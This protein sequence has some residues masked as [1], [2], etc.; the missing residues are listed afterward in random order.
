MN[1]CPICGTP[2]EDKIRICPNCG[3]AI[4]SVPAANPEDTS[5][6]YGAPVQTS[7]SMPESVPEPMPKSMPDPS[8][9]PMPEPVPEPM[10]EPSPDF[11]P[12]L[13]PDDVPVQPIW[14][15]DSK[16]KPSDG[17]L[18][19]SFL[20]DPSFNA[21]VR[22]DSYS[23]K[24]PAAYDTQRDSSTGTDRDVDIFDEVADS[25]SL[26]FSNMSPKIKKFVIITIITTLLSIIPFIYMS[27]THQSTESIINN[28]IP[29]QTSWPAN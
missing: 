6:L 12:G 21:P 7:F 18:D 8:P 11:M 23:K 25:A 5:F 9:E 19:E 4:G 22:E 15:T 28:I 13:S 1:L 16:K 20:N 17:P 10:P 14:V 26:I 27:C 24:N 3:N 2:Y 29:T